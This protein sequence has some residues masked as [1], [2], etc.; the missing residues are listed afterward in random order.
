MFR[1]GIMTFIFGDSL[2]FVGETQ[3]EEGLGTT[4]FGRCVDNLCISLPLYHEKEPI[5]TSSLVEP[6]S[7]L[8]RA[9]DN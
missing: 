7:R 8:I 1:I 9:T 5:S 4:N 6:S 3:G 2:L